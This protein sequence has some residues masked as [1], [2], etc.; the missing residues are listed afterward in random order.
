MLNE[1]LFLLAMILLGISFVSYRSMISTY[2]VFPTILI[3]T[4]GY[5]VWKSHSWKRRTLIIVPTAIFIAG[6]LVLFYLF[7]YKGYVLF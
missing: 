2:G 7:K 5:L 4:A 1:F 3:I 6:G